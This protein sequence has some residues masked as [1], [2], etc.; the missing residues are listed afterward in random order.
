MATVDTLKAALM[1]CALIISSFKNRNSQAGY[2]LREP[3]GANAIITTIDALVTADET[4]PKKQAVIPQIAPPEK[5]RRAKPKPL[6]IPRLQDTE[7]GRAMLARGV[8]SVRGDL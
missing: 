4:A 8:D 1:E 3:P 6:S 7:A 2:P 5:K